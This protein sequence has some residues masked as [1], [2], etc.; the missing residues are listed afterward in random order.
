MLNV[1]IFRL[2]APFPPAAADLSRSS[3]ELAVMVGTVKR[4]TRKVSVVKIWENRVH[5]YTISD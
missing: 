2:Q 5:N 4:R 3:P 1:K